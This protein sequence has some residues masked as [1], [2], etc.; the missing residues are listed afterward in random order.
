VVVNLVRSMTLS[1]RKS[2]WMLVL[3]D[4]FIE[5]ADTLAIPDVSTPV[6][7]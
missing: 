3:T 2:N 5:W 1:T 4:H 7:A 6:N